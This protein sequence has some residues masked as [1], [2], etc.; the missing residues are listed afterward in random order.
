M[1]IGEPFY[2]HLYPSDKCIV[3]G[4]GNTVVKGRALVN[5]ESHNRFH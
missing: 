2:L 4:R 1:R 5:S 3:D